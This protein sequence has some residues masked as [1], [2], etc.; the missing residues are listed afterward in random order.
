MNLLGEEA[1]NKNRVTLKDDI[2]QIREAILSLDR[3]L[4]AT[5]HD[6]DG[7]SGAVLLHHA[8][9]DARV[10]FPHAF[11]DVKDKDD[12]VIDMAPIPASY[13]GYVIDHHP[14]YRHFGRD[15]DY[16]LIFDNKPASLITLETFRDYIPE[17]YMWKVL[18][19]T[20]GDVSPEKTPNWVWKTCPSLFDI[21]SRLGKPIRSVSDDRIYPSSYPL[22]FMLSSPVNALARIGEPEMAFEKFLKMKDP[23]DVL[24]D[25]TFK[26]A[27]TRLRQEVARIYSEDRGHIFNFGPIM[28]WEINSDLSMAGELASREYETKHITCV[29]LNAQRKRGSVRGVLCKYIRDNL[30]K[31]NINGHDV[32]MGLSLRADQDVN[33]F[34][35]DLRSIIFR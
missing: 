22:Y 3:P 33:D 12:I 32:A 20:V 17:Q 24:R 5:H 34:R 16:N 9:G 2:D 26:I 11:G 14:G 4:I 13:S 21:C 6:S 19:G 23:I 29:V 31:Y 27:Q 7:I 35:K 28:Y 8:L 10:R 25:N 1:S 18:V 30:P 15:R